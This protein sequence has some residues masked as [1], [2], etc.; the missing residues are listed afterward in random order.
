MHYILWG[1]A[2]HALVLSDL[3]S[4]RQ[5]SVIALFDND[6]Q[7][8][9]VL[10]GVPIHYGEQ[11]FLAWKGSCDNTTEVQA[12]VAIGG[13]R[14]IDRRKVA[15]LFRTHGITVPI[16]IHPHAYVAA[17]ARIGEGSQ[18]LANSMVGSKAIL[19]AD[20]IVNSSAN[21]D[22]ECEL[23]SGVHVAPGATL[24][25][26]V[27]VGENSFIGAGACVLP[28]VVIGRGAIVGAGAVVT[29]DVPDRAVVAGNPARVVRYQ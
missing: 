4:L 23:A 1:S 26:C 27:S 16:L 24:C 7:A 25:G 28:R 5:A 12:A 13:S 20:C 19:G 22:H 17:S 14:G 3:L 29:K 15:D 10:E 21:V 11:G 6:I 18:I 9:S 2:G 8:R